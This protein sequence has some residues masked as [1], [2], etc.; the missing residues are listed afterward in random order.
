M[1]RA[2]QVEGQMSTFQSVEGGWTDIN[3][4]AVLLPDLLK[5]LN[6]TNE[7]C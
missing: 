6:W 5:S 2:A 7:D 4:D 1:V 3:Y